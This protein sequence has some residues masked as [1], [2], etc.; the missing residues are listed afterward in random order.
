MLSHARMLA[1]HADSL[2]APADEA[3]LLKKKPDHE[4]YAPAA[5]RMREA[6]LQAQS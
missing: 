4:R 3:G 5:R 2:L 6:I 1:T